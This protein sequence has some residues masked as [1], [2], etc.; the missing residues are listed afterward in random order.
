MKNL[1]PLHYFLGIQVQRTVDTMFFSQQKYICDLLTQF[2]MLDCKPCLTPSYS[3]K[4]DNTSGEI[5]SNP[6]TYIYLVGAL[7]YL[8]WTRPK[9]AFL[10]NQVC[11]HMHTPRTPHL[12]EENLE[13]S[14]R[15]TSSWLA[16][17]QR[18]SQPHSLFR[19]RL[20]WLSH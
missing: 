18:K 13:I 11:Q 17:S 9:I 19:R 4:L 2:F 8:T 10:V 20:G 14:K 12:R 5:L 1:G 7:Q 16:P 6:I 15:H 3:K